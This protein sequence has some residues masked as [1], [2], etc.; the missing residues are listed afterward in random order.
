MPFCF[1]KDSHDSFTGGQ[2]KGKGGGGGSGWKQQFMKTKVIKHHWNQES[3]S[4]QHTRK[5]D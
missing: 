1:C 5:A 3:R 2:G 4:E